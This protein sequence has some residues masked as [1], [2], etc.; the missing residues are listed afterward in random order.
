MGDMSMAP[1]KTV[2]AKART[3]LHDVGRLAFRVPAAHIETADK[4][5]GNTK[6]AVPPELLYKTEISELSI[7]AAAA[8]DT[9]FHSLLLF[10]DHY[11]IK[12][13]LEETQ[14]RS[15]CIDAPNYTKDAP[16]CA[17]TALA[18]NK[19]RH[20]NVWKDLAESYPDYS[21]QVAGLEKVLKYAAEKNVVP[22]G[23]L[24]HLPNHLDNVYRDCLSNLWNKLREKHPSLIWLKA[25]VSLKTKLENEPRLED[26]DLI[27][28]VYGNERRYF[29]KGPIPSACWTLSMALI[30]RLGPTWFNKRFDGNKLTADMVLKARK[31]YGK[32]MDE[33]GSKAWNL[34][35]MNGKYVMAAILSGKLKIEQNV[36]G[37]TQGES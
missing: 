24:R 6:K 8:D 15:K 34:G 7:A 29:D 12:C 16:K 25:P 33:L 11:V 18:E 2:T 20:D 10:K 32:M 31:E 13:A 37:A 36:G 30:Y 5:V 22:L 9:L 3:D 14:H 23:G 28:A 4:P 1:K 27:R 17:K 35:N 26:N 19:A 21:T